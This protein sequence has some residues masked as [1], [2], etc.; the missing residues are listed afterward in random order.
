MNIETQL[1]NELDFYRKTIA[2]EKDGARRAELKIALTKKL[3][4][5]SEILAEAVRPEQEEGR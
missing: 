4:A 2:G 1:K 3:V 5:I